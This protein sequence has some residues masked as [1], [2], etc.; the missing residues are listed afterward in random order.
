MDAL[1]IRWMTF[2]RFRIFLSQTIDGE[3]S[4]SNI[5]FRHNG[6]E[7]HSRTGIIIKSQRC[8]Y[9]RFNF[10]RNVEG[11]WSNAGENDEHSTFIISLW[12]LNPH[13]WVLMFAEW[14]SYP[15]LSVHF[16]P[17]NLWR[18]SKTEPCI[19]LFQVPFLLKRVDLIYWNNND[20]DNN[21]TSGS[22]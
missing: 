4:W 2:L 12:L 19:S 7:F 8:Q 11:K 10:Y 18:V 3:R 20:D 22:M 1:F 13:N 21:K 17:T 5:S 14:C 9:F 6:N 15:Y 16:H